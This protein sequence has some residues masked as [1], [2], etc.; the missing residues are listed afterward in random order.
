[1]NVLKCTR[2]GTRIG[3]LCKVNIYLFLPV[4]KREIKVLRGEPK[5]AA[6]ETE[7]VSY[8]AGGYDKL[9]IQFQFTFLHL[10]QFPVMEPF[11]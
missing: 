7:L 2:T 5:P 1:M 11:Y 4:I 6:Y 9:N 3:M 10:Q 8:S